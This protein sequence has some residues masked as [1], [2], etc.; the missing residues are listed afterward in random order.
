MTLLLLLLAALLSAAI[1]V[2]GHSHG[3]TKQL[4]ERVAQLEAG[5]E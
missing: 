1:A 5:A 3:V 2:C 4:R